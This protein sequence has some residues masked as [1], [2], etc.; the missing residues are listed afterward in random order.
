MT[1]TARSSRTSQDDAPR[2]AVS[3]R[4]VVKRFGRG[5]DMVTALDDVSLDIR[6]NEFFTMLGPSGCGK[7]TLLRLIAGFELPDAGAI[8]LDG[9]EIAHLPPHKRPVNTV[10]QNY[11][12]FPHM[13]VA[14]NIGFGLEMQGR[15]K[16][17]AAQT[18]ERMLTLEAAFPGQ[19]SPG[20][21]QTGGKVA[22]RP[23][24][25]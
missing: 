13:T 23:D 15:P 14:Q 25:S 17:E 9:A 6:E 22:T 1:L 2:V 4:G 3:A 5:A 24:T 21:Q 16:A 7:T 10:F 19:R 11:A 18:V 20:R 12:L 8:S